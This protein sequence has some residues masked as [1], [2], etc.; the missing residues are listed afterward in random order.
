MRLKDIKMFGI[1]WDFLVWTFPEDNSLYFAQIS[2]Q[3]MNVSITL[4]H[5]IFCV[6]S[7]L[8]QKS[9]W[10][11]N[12]NSPSLLIKQQHNR[13]RAKLYYDLI[14]FGS[15]KGQVTKAKLYLCRNRCVC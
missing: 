12:E 14:S 10:A 2:Y 5:F 1:S 11:W 3:L 15:K 9:N 6:F 7:A 13:S 8:A 4:Y